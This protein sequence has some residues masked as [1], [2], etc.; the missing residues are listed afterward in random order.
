MRRGLFTGVFCLAL[1]VRLAYLL[2]QGELPG[3][4]T[5]MERAA[6]SLASGGALGNV[7]AP[8]SGP[9]AH[10]APLYP[11]LL[12]LIY[13]AAGVN[14]PGARYA[15]AIV[16]CV[17]TALL[18]SL[19]PGL[20]RRLGLPSFTASATA[21]LLSLSPFNLWIETSGTWE[22]PLAAL[23][24]VLLLR[25]FVV[26][27]GDDWMRTR[28]TALVSILIGVS[29][30]FSAT[31]L[32]A[33][34]LMLFVE[35]LT[36][37]RSRTHIVIACGASAVAVAVCVIPWGLR[38]R[39]VLGA[40]VPLRSNFGLELS[41]GNHDAATGIAAYS[42]TPRGEIVRTSP[43]HPFA[44]SGEYERLRRVG[45]AS[46]MS[47]RLNEAVEWIRENPGRF[48]ALTAHR[49]RLFWFPSEMLWPAGAPLRAVRPL[50]FGTVGLLA[51]IN[52]VMMFA[53]SN[54]YRWLILAVFFA[55]CVL[56]VITHV[57]ARYTYPVFALQVLLA[58]DLL[59]RLLAPLM[60]KRTVDAAGVFPIEG[61]L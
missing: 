56:Y 12:A 52:L 29:A 30:L 20:A 54:P 46:Y 11:G 55:S 16:A 34:M 53:R 27:H 41:I 19:I 14:S 49:M 6:M 24:I 23:W 22:Q 51:W 36:Q 5:E 43:R 48:A 7:Y 21:V 25:L 37:R 31:V 18:I 26:Q 10:V 2:Y 39:A 47:E 9:S 32:I 42:M 61:Q 44:N 60:R 17:I 15:Q 35:L 13:L 3:G 8:D 40:F 58:V 33:G 45:E 57:T 4:D 59:E 28:R 1:I 50:L 38:N